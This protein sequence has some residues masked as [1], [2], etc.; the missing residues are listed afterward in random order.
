MADHFEFSMDEDY[1]VFEDAEDGL[2]DHPHI[3]VPF[4]P[5]MAETSQSPRAL[6][7]PDLRVPHRWWKSWSL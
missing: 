5:L 2:D 3:Q 6:L 4:C 7:T 1:E